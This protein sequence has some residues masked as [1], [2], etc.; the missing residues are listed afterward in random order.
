MRLHM[1]SGDSLEM[2]EEQMLRRFQLCAST[3]LVET[4]LI[5]SGAFDFLGFQLCASTWL[6]ETAGV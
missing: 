4:S 2:S 5:F 6:V 3:W 1:V